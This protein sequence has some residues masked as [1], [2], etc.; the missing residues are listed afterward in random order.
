MRKK[1]PLLN[2]LLE[3][4]KENNTIFSMPGNKCGKAFLRDD[5]GKEFKENMGSLDITEV[6]PLDNLHHP[7]GVIK[8]AQEHLA[9]LYK[10]KKAFFLVNGSTNG[11][12][13]AI[14]SA[15][16][17]GDEILVERNCHKSIYNAIILRKL[18]VTYIEPWIFEK[19]GLFL[20]PNESNI[21]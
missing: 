8:E 19:G 2:A 20:P 4:S 18:K 3:Y 11:N 13:A 6:D 9:N 7:Q 5:I 10:V 14:F 15:F 17:E 16:K 1:L 12:L 21:Y